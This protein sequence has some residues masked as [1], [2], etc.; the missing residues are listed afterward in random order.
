MYAHE[1]S[2]A[3]APG[4]GADYVAKPLT[5]S[6]LVLGPIFFGGSCRRLHPSSL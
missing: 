6:E 1:L 2:D 5:I 3:F 4:M